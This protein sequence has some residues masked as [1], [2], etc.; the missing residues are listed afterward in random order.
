MAADQHVHEETDSTAGP[1]AKVSAE[2]RGALRLWLSFAWATAPLLVALPAG[3]CFAWAAWKLRS[4]WLALCAGV[5]IVGTI[6]FGALAAETDWRGDLAGA[7]GLAVMAGATVHAL[8]IRRRVFN[9]VR[10][11]TVMAAPP[12]QDRMA[13]FPASPARSDPLDPA[14]WHLPFSCTGHD[15][16]RLG[17]PLGQTFGYAA[18]GAALLAATVILDLSE[19]ALGPALGALLVPVLVAM[20]S[21]ELDGSTLRYRWWGVSRVL[22]LDEVGS[23]RV[24][25][26]SWGSSTL[27]LE[28]PGQ[29]PIRVALRTAAYVAEPQVRQHLRGCWTD[30]G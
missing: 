21:Q 19:R 27:V 7:V 12:P 29:R 1:R 18:S 30:Q 11:P 23:V 15:R 2:E 24:A 26:R 22:R 25:P 16:H 28:A 8:V 20:F 13:S 9:L 4:R 5:Y 3:P 10:P 14:T 6:V 17:L